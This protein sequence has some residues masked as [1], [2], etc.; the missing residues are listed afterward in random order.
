MRIAIL[1]SASTAIAVALALFDS[2]P[3]EAARNRSVT[4]RRAPAA[5]VVK[6]RTLQ[7]QVKTR[8]VPKV[9]IEKKI[10]TKTP[11][12]LKTDKKIITKTPLVGTGSAAAFVKKGGP[13]LKLKG[14]PITKAVASTPMRAGRVSLPT[15]KDFKPKL[16]LAKPPKVQLQYRMAPFVQ[17]HWKKA[18][19]WVAVAGIGYLTIPE[20]YYERF[21]GYVDIEDPDYEGCIHLL[22]LAAFEE[23]EEIIRVRRPMP[24]NAA[25]RYS[26]SVAPEPAVSSGP[27]CALEPFIERSWSRPFVWVQ[28][29]KIGNVTVPEEYYDRFYDFVAAAPPNYQSACTVLVEAA[30]A[31]TVA[32]TSFDFQRPEFR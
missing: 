2:T 10:V 14:L 19:F 16:A 5:T 20:I 27:S 26:A 7:R 28:I 9:K 8:H 22:S 17:R 32:T 15:K 4:V 12:K 31:D 29:P 24:A 1:A 3:A 11:L 23:E 30:A 21:L 18:F 25:Y 13:Q 6:P